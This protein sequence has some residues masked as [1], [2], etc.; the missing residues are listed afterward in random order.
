MTV[1][2]DA[3]AQIREAQLAQ[4]NYILVVGEKE[5]ERST[6]NARTRDNAVHGEQ[7]LETVLG[8]MQRERSE[9]SL[10]GLWASDGDDAA[11]AS[12]SAALAAEASA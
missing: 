2:L 12:S 11:A 10:V 7:Q 1:V 4:Y 6:V 8:V 5:R 9:R 3:A